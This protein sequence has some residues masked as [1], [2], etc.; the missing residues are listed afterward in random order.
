MGPPDWVSP[1]IT[2]SYTIASYS[3]P[4][5]M[6]DETEAYVQ[7]MA[8]A[9]LEEFNNPP[10]YVIASITAPA[11]QAITWPMLESACLACPDYKLLHSSIQAG[12]PQESKDWDPKLLP[13]F[14]HRHLLTTTGPVVLINDRPVVP[15]SLRARAIDHIHAG[16]PGLSTMCQRMAASLYWPDY[17]ADLTKAKLSCTTCRTIAPSLPAM[18]PNAP[19]A[20]TYPFQSIVCDFF[21][22][23]GR[24]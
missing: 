4:N 14:R 13:Y 12:L 18:P 23:A 16:H 3:L 10:E 5:H 15:K 7:G 6:E 8:L 2:A 17:K 24:T 19:S 9:R 21:S 11:I 1:P 22:M 20:P